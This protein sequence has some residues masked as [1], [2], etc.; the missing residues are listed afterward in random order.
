MKKLVC[1]LALMLTLSCVFSLTACGG[2]TAT[3]KY[4]MEDCFQLGIRQNEENYDNVKF[5]DLMNNTPS[6]FGSYLM[7]QT[8]K[9]LKITK[10]TCSYYTDEIYKGDF[11][12]DKDTTNGDDILKTYSVNEEVA[13]GKW[14]SN[15]KKIFPD[16]LYNLVFEFEVIE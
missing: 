16:N 4:T 7:I 2:E 12:I 1:F 11:V 5:Q 14:L 6:K 15:N 3:K 9:T 10:I 13:L 8:K